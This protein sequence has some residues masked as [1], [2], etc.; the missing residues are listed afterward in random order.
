VWTRGNFGALSPGSALRLAA[1]R[2]RILTDSRT[3]NFSRKPL[4]GRVEGLILM[5]EVLTL[6]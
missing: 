1:A 6:V 5:P 3:S 2:P 4:L